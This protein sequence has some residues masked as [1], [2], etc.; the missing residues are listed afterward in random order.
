MSFRPGSDDTFIFIPQSS[1]GAIVL[2][3]STQVGNGVNLG[4]AGT[5]TL[6][7]DVTYG[8][9]VTLADDDGRTQV[10]DDGLLL[11]ANNV[12]LGAAGTVTLA[13]NSGTTQYG[14]TNSR[15]QVDAGTLTLSN[16]TNTFGGPGIPPGTIIVSV[17]PSDT[18]N[19]GGDIILTGIGVLGSDASSSFADWTIL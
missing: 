17:S 16:T 10:L 8:G 7:G 2:V 18:V 1:Y 6:G 19:N 14:G 4:A 11:P 3:G 9:T 5:I 12:S 15:I 13:S